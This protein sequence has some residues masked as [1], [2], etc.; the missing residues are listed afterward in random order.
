MGWAATVRLPSLESSLLS[1]AP[2]SVLSCLSA[3][4]VDL[5]TVHSITYP[6]NIHPRLCGFSGWT[7]SGLDSLC[8][9]LCSPDGQL[10]CS[11]LPH[12][13]L[14]M[15]QLPLYPRGE[16]ASSPLVSLSLK[17]VNPTHLFPGEGVFERWICFI[18]FLF[19][20]C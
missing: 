3:L 8:T 10:S 4:S 14:G 16:P 18:S 12:R 17:K 11:R 1:L 19:S 2:G 9:S 5:A 20:F 6:S 13:A 15:G 7:P